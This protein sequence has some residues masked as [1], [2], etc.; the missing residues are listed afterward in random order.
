VKK[1]GGRSRELFFSKIEPNRSEKDRRVERTIEPWEHQNRNGRQRRRQPSVQELKS[2]GQ[3]SGEQ[4]RR[5]P[6][7]GRVLYPDPMLISR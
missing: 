3:G 1:T 5:T 7:L 4:F 2:M 6:N